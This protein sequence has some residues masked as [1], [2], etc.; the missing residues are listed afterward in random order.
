M[1]T[2]YQPGDRVTIHSRGAP[3]QRGAVLY[4]HTYPFD[5]FYGITLDHGGTIET[6]AAWLTPEA[7]EAETRNPASE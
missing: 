1:P 3:G 7:P 6:S 4:V 2:T 5:R